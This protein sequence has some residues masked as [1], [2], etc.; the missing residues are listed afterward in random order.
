MTPTFVDQYLGAARVVSEQAIG[1]PA[2]SPQE[3]PKLFIGLTVFMLMGCPWVHERGGGRH[4]FPSDGDYLLNIGSMAS[5]LSVGS[6]EH[7]NTMIATVDGKKFFETT[8][9]GLEESARL[10]QLRAPAVD[11][12]NARLRDIPLTTTAGPHKVAV[13]FLHR[14]FAESDEPYSNRFRGKARRRCPRRRF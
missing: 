4:Y 3:P 6:M 14:S 10:D 13:F 2:A 11:E 1:Y 12:L 7:E 5:G 9:G 8:I